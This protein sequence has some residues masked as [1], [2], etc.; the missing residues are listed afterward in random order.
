MFK[1]KLKRFCAV[2][3]A[4]MMVVSLAACSTSKSSKDSSPKKEQSA[5]ATTENKKSATPDYVASGVVLPDNFDN[6]IYPVEALMVQQ[7]TKGY[8]YYSSKSSEDESDSLWFSMAVLT[9]LMEEN[10]AYGDGIEQ[11]GY[12]YLKED[13]VNMYASALY[14]A[15]GKGDLEFPEIADGEKYVTY[16][17]SKEMYGFLKGTVG[18]LT[19]YITDCTKDGQDYVLEVQ[20]RNSETDDIKGTYEIVLTK[21]DYDGDENY[22]NYSVAA[23][24]EKSK[25]SSNDFSGESTS[26]K[27]E[28]KKSTEESTS[29]EGTTDATDDT[30]DTKDT[31]SNDSSSDAI[32]Q[33]DALSQAKDYYGDDAEYSYKKKVKVGDKDYYD[34]SVKGD[35]ISS[36]DVLVSVDGQDV[37]GGVKNEDGS[38]SFD[39]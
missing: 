26:N 29:E 6:M 3:L 4:G 24:K 21:T 2:T 32:S 8:P 20:L 33:D 27:S 5:E 38:W 11:E 36:T 25:S 7:N 22:F 23:I 37:M 12:Y 28:E 13:T 31:D 34:F 17:D 15:Y 39:Q 35:G 14:D 9:S 18:N 19:S 10:S 30:E 16:D 1:N